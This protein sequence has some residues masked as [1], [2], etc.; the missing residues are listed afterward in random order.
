MLTE[1]IVGG[2]FLNVFITYE[3]ILRFDKTISDVINISR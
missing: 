3:L 1:N 2:D